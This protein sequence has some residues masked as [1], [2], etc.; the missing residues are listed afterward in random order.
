MF[1]KVLNA[2]LNVYKKTSLPVK[3]KKYKNFVF[4]SGK[5]V[6]LFLLFYKQ[7]LKEKVCAK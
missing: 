5:D 1:G 7:V 4:F 6:F 2:L 3:K